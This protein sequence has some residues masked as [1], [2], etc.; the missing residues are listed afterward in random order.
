MSLVFE[1]DLRKARAN[2]LK[3]SV[4]FAEATSVFSDPLARIFEDEYHSADEPREIILGHSR[5]ARLLFGTAA[6]GRGTGAVQQTACETARAGRPRP[7]WPGG[8]AG[9]GGGGVVCA[10]AGDYGGAAGHAGGPG[11][12]GPVGRPDRGVLPGQYP[13]AGAPSRPDRPAEQHQQTGAGYWPGVECG[14][15]GGG[16]GAGAGGVAEHAGHG[17]PAAAGAGRDGA[18]ADLG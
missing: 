14:G 7:A 15:G 17:G 11:R 1:W 5:T 18:Q 16:A 4:S 9:A 13:D 8:G 10:G 12:A 2:L 6:A 3:H